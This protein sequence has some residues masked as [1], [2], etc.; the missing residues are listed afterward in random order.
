[1]LGRRDPTLGLFGAQT[2]LVLKD[3]VKDLGFYAQVAANWRETFKDDDFAAMYP[4]RGRRSHPPSVM[5]TATLLQKHEQISDAEVVARTRFDLRWKYV[6]DLDPCSTEALFAKSAYQAYRVR[7]ALHGKQATLFEKSV[8]EACDR[9]LLPHALRLALDTTPIRGRGALKDAYNLLSDA[10]ALIV[11]QVAQASGVEP[12]DVA[13]EIGVER[14]VTAPSIKGS[15]F[16]DW[17]DAQ[18]TGHFLAGLLEDARQAVSAAEQAGCASEEVSLLRTVVAEN[19]EETGELPRI[20]KGVPKER[21]TSV[22]DPDM[23][24]GHK[25]TG[26][27]YTGHKGHYAI[28]TTNR[29]I[30]AIDVSA[31][32]ESEGSRVGTLLKQSQELTQR[33]IELALGDTAYSSRTAQAEAQEVAVPLITKMPSPPKGSFGPGAFDVSEDG[34]SARC[35]AGHP[36]S[37]LGRRTMKQGD[38]RVEFLLHTWTDDL[39]APCP[40][41]E[42]CLR[43]PGKGK[44]RKREQRMLRVL[45]DYHERREREAFARSEEGRTLLRE[46]VAV[47]HTIGQAKNHG[48]GQA[49]YMGRAKTHFEQLCTAALL[50]FKKIWSLASQPTAQAAVAAA[51][52]LVCCLGPCFEQHVQSALPTTLSCAEWTT[53]T[54]PPTTSRTQSPPAGA[55][56]GDLTARDP[57]L[58]EGGPGQPARSRPPRAPP[59]LARPH[60]SAPHRSSTPLQTQRPQLRSRAGAIPATPR[61]ANK[62]SS[63]PGRREARPPPHGLSPTKDTHVARM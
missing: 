33:P 60:A 15:E 48:A 20:A 2:R 49:S 56:A 27:L 58:A 5:A 12:E 50:N 47:E 19:V 55:T 32:A 21:T 10:I 16:V 18:S 31:P 25:S 17:D 54:S 42:Q 39:C 35:P 52:L 34:E 13:R 11:R 44:Q 38:E 7:L 57:P 61:P 63:E 3:P 41:K 29:I 45:P 59:L 14:H 53:P 30:T 1:M 8:R 23:K 4:W 9:G 26:K 36:S 37:K 6:F 24:H 62:P 28:E 51:L 46:R 43:K 40:L 22:H